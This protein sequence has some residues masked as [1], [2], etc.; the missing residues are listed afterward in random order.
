MTNSPR[1]STRSRL[2]VPTD[3][4]QLE[5]LRSELDATNLQLL[6]TLEARGRLVREIMA[7]KRRLGWP[8]YDPER[9]RMM[10]ET[11]LRRAADV[12]PQAALEQVFRAIFAASR[13]LGAEVALSSNCTNDGR[14]RNRY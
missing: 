10:T 8:A 14:M 6:A 13:A 7:I 12:Y 5:D 3:V 9:E 1:H 4:Q 2:E 11:L